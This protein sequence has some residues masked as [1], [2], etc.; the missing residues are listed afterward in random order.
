MQQG[1]GCHQGLLES[2][3]LADNKD[4]DLVGGGVSVMTQPSIS[5][6]LSKLPREE[7]WHGQGHIASPGFSQRQI[8][9]GVGD[10]GGPG[11]GMD[12]LPPGSGH[13]PRPYPSLPPRFG[14][15]GCVRDM[16]PPRLQDHWMRMW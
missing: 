9:P 14:G 3:G 11:D 12:A 13:S 1:K 16:A 4:S 2:G 8:S 5:D 10:G 6:H 7:R 15:Q